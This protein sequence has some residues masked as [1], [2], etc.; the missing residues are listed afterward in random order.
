[1]KSI[2]VVAAIIWD[3]NREKLL[4][5]QR[6]DHLHKGGC[7]EFPGG[8]VEGGETEK[9]A[10]KRE[11]LEE[12]NI[13]FDSCQFFQQIE[14]SYPEKNVKLDFYHVYGVEIQ[15]VRANEGQAWRWIH[16]QELTEYQFP[17]ANQP[18]VGALLKVDS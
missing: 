3:E 16:K 8:K 17:E 14:F 9:E 4:I 6:P 2:H 10:L 12:L 1:M 11:L 18:I 15:D 5:S 7:W 13:Q